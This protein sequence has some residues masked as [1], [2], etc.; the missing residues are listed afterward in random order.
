[1]TSAISRP[2]FAVCTL[3]GMAAFAGFAARSATGAT[4]ETVMHD[5]VGWLMGRWAGNGNLIPAS[6][7]PEPY[8]C[9]VTYRRADDGHIQQNLRCTGAD[10]KFDASTRLKFDGARVSGQWQ[11]NIHSLSGDVSGA[12]T[13]SGFEISLTGQFFSAAMRVAG[14]ECQQDVTLIPVKADQIR[15]MSASLRKC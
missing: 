15:Q 1:M 6:G 14:S 4:P 12:V 5:T 13:A 9:V 2:L 11:E 10:S 7:A 8:K 3:A